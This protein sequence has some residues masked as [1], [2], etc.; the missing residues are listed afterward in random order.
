MSS[1]IMAIKFKVEKFRS[2]MQYVD[3]NTNPIWRTYAILKIDFYYIF[4]LYCPINATFG[5]RKQN[6]IMTRVT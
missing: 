3:V 4:A 1:L 2:R 6:D 5:Y